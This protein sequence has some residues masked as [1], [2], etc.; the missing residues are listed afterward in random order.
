[1]I[2]RFLPLLTLPLMLVAGL[3][4][5]DHPVASPFE[6][7]LQAK[8]APGP[9][10]DKAFGDPTDLPAAMDAGAAYL[11]TMQADVT[12]DNAGNGDPDTDPD[13]GG[14]DW[15]M[16]TFSHS[17]GASA[18][19]LYGVTAQGLYRGYL[20]H[21]TPAVFTAM[22]D[23]ADMIV[24]RGPTEVRSGPDIIFL[25]HF[26]DLP[27]VADPSVYRNAALAIWNYQ[28][29]AHGGGAGIATYIRDMRAGQGY[30]NGIIPWDTAPW[31]EGLMLLDVAFPGNGY[32]AESVAAA[33]VLWQ[34]S[35]NANPGYFE[36]FG[37]SQGFDPNWATP[38]YWW[39]D[40]GVSGLIR[41]FATAGVHTDELPALQQALLDCQYPDGSFSDQYG[42][43]YPPDAAWN[44]A[45]GQATAYAVKALYENLT[46]TTATMTA[47]Y[48]G[49][50][51]IAATQ[52]AS[53]AWVYGSG[54]H[55]PEIGGECT[56]ALAEGWLSGGTALAAVPA[57]TS[58]INCGTD[59]VV[60]F[61]YTPQPGAP[62]LK[63]YAVTISAGPEVSFGVADVADAGSLGAIGEHYFDVVDNGDGTLTINDAIL[64]TTAGLQTG[65][66]LF[67]VTFHPVGD[68]T[69]NVSIDSY[70]LRD[71]DNGDIFADVTNTTITVDCTAPPAV[72][73]ITA[74]PGNQQVHV[75]WAMADE[76]D[77]DHYEVYR[78]LWYDTTPGT[79][80]YPEYDDLAGSTI[81]ARPAD[82]NAAV[83]S[84]EWELAGTVTAGT[85]TFIDNGMTTGRGV[86][87]YEVFAVDAAVNY[88][89]PAAANDRATNYWLGDVDPA[90]PDGDVD[91]GDITVMGATFGLGDGD[92]GYD[93]EVD[94]GPT[95]DHS[96]YGIP[97]TDSVIDFED[98]MIFALNYGNVGLKQAPVVVEGPI[99]LVWDR[100]D[101]RTWVLRLDEGSEGLKGIRIV[102]PLPAGAGCSIAAGEL[103]D[104]QSGPV[105]LRNI[106]RKGLDLSL[107]LIGRGLT[108]TGGGELVRLTFDRPLETAPVITARGADNADLAV[109]MAPGQG[110]LPRT[111]AAAQNYPN[112]FNPST[113]IEYRLPE[114]RHVRLG[115]YALDGKL[116]R[117]LVDGNM[118]A[119]THT[120]VWNGRDEN[121]RQVASGTYFYRIQA[122]DD[123]VT[124]KMLLTK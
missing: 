10:S 117:M 90:T 13:D 72:T 69:A 102:A 84:A 8:T 37:H 82:R 70:K 81:P 7:T 123:V 29:T 80:A 18:P 100:L 21:P 26:A 15:V 93:N 57:D 52:D 85:L 19:N 121:D 105:F 27:G 79:S 35:F 11:V 2:R 76:S 115:V 56:M 62:G 48:R 12:E 63:G 104:R 9:L 14:W 91:S 24:S 94:V 54:N 20:Q 64:G 103:L 98:L 111:F 110:A 75:S 41:A 34:D 36:P 107:A 53:G 50:V 97:L 83:A 95:D 101:D 118:P 6:Q 30:A 96:G 45:E 86:Y 120:A 3:A 42:A 31:V 61:T 114:Q 99:V 46:H 1:M 40:I 74:D 119:G 87:Y 47:A 88:G 122:G 77:V 66:P 108:F 112:P 71:P 78:G 60:T 73:G 23:A 89:P 4:W 65:A 17:A 16:T 32:A 38:D 59:K 109:A 67:S 116:V 28:D 22:Q 5:A 92:T 33:E 68:G 58:P 124:R 43:Q 49:A 51:W 55:Y 113:R 106:E 25:L 39:Y 44:D